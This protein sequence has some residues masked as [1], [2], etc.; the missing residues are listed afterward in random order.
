MLKSFR[1]SPD[2][3]EDKRSLVLDENKFVETFLRCLICRE[4]YSSDSRPPKLLPCHH[5]LCL[6]CILNIYHAEAEYRRGFVPNVIVSTVTI[7]CPTCRKHFISAEAGLTQ[8][9]TDH[10]VVQLID[11]VKHTDIQTVQYCT[12]HKKQHLNFFCELCC[13]LVCRDCTI[14]DHKEAQGHRVLDIEGAIKKYTPVIDT[15]MSEV[16]KEAVALKEKRLVVGQ[17]IETM[18][19]AEEDLVGS[20]RTSFGRLKTLLEERERELIEAAEKDVECEKEKLQE[21]ADEIDSRTKE[22]EKKYK[23]LK[24]IKDDGDVESLYKTNE[25]MKDYKPMNP[26]KVKQIDDGS[27]TKFSF[28]DRDEKYLNSR[29]QN[30]GEVVSQME[31]S[32]SKPVSTFASS[33]SYTSG[34][35]SAHRYSPASYAYGGYNNYSKFGKR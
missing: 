35:A 15:V 23:E 7:V 22:L 25:E 31:S 1:E 28:N 6:T 34:Y 29:I 16:E 30:F 24:S 9:P 14:L 11:F 10:R 32:I 19:K 2:P 13:S 18:N 26:I 20:I 17:A 12:K 27:L 4:L 3:V 21:K 8:L 5:S 33:S